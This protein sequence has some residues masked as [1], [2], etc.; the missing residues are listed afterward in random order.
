[1]KQYR[2]RGILN[3]GSVNSDQFRGR[4]DKIALAIQAAPRRHY[5]Q[6]T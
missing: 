1:M 2:T 4:W 5:E 6:K 3:F